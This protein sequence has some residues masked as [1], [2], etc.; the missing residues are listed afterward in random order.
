MLPLPIVSFSPSIK[1]EGFR[2]SKTHPYQQ[3]PFLS[4]YVQ[5][6]HSCFAKLR[7]CRW[8]FRQNINRG[9]EETILCFTLKEDFRRWVIKRTFN[10]APDRILPKRKSQCTLDMDTYDKK[11]RSN[12]EEQRSG[13]YHYTGFWFCTP[14]RKKQTS[15]PAYWECLEAVPAAE[16]LFLYYWGTRMKTRIHPEARWWKLTMVGATNNLAKRRLGL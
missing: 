9:T 7:P 8:P 3:Y 13:S 16:V 15:A 4:C 1:P 6:V 5:F 14:D 12:P 2:S 11:L 10:K